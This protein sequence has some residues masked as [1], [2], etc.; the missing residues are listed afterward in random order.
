MASLLFSFYI[1]RISQDATW[2]SFAA[3]HRMNLF[4]PY[5]ESY[6]GFKTRYVKVLPVKDAP[7]TM[8]GEPIPWYW[9]MPNQV[10]GMPIDVPAETA[11][12]KEVPPRAEAISER[13]PLVSTDQGTIAVVAIIDSST[14]MATESAGQMAHS[15]NS[16]KGDSNAVVG[17]S[18]IG[19]LWGLRLD[20]SSLKLGMKLDARDCELH[21]LVAQRIRSKCRRPHASERQPL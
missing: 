13:A 16:R 18:E 8:D 6:K 5:L 21:F 2:V 12:A 15:T 19:S 4:C 10:E 1:A 14:P 20:P 17:P 9:H 11:I 3:I 7:L